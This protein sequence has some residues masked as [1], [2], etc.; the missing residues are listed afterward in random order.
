M[1]YI[2]D[3]DFKVARKY[4]GYRPKEVFENDLKELLK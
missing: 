1:T 3:K 4:I 2:I